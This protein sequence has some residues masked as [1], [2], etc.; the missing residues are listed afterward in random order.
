MS[1]PL[2]LS[3]ELTIPYVRARLDGLKKQGSDDPMLEE[4]VDRFYLLC[5]DI[6]I[7]ECVGDLDSHA[8]AEWFR[9]EESNNRQTTGHAMHERI[10]YF[11]KLLEPLAACVPKTQLFDKIKQLKSLTETMASVLESFALPEN[12]HLDKSF[13]INE[14]PAS[15]P[16]S[17]KWSIDN[18]LLFLNETIRDY[19]DLPDVLFGKDGGMVN[20]ISGRMLEAIKNCT[21]TDA[22]KAHP[23]VDFEQNLRILHT[24]S[25]LVDDLWC[26]ILNMLGTK[27]L[28]DVIWSLKSPT[29]KA[30]YLKL[31]KF[32]QSKAVRAFKDPS[33]AQ[34]DA[35]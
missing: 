15:N 14:R 34:V 28:I 27:Y 6:T 22:F 11:G 17:T 31:R 23:I 21:Q 5:A 8:M 32:K 19:I 18:S 12:V 4:R 7:D 33:K 35:A 24:V 13:D 16:S 26:D 29:I 30:F 1:Q 2:R 25:G 20:V 10:K 3:Q 9:L